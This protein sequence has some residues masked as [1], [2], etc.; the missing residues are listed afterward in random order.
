[1]I[2]KRLKALADLV[3]SNSSVI[4]IG[5]DHA[6]LPI[7]L[8]EN[9]IT[10]DIIASD[11]S[12]KVLQ[13]SLDNLKKYNLDNDIS[14]IQSDGFKNIALKYDVA[15]I[16]GMGIYT[17]KKILNASNRSDI[18]IIQSNNDHYELRKYLNE[19]GYKIDKEIVVYDNK[20]YYDIIRFRKGEEKLTKEELLFGKSNN[21]VYYKYLLD[22]YKYIYDKSNNKKY[23]EY[24]T[25]LN[26]LIE[27]IPE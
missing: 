19:L 11:I 4:D 27:K 16:A 7:Y 1:M 13:S 10:K 22:K 25:I 24:I 6:Y 21:K 2:S 23:L 5:T 20:K 9:N 8:Y 12:E 26:N 3:P 17:I 18:L 15:V 14:L